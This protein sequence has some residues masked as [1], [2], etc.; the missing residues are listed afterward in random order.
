VFDLALAQQLATKGEAPVLND[1]RVDRPERMIVVSGPNQG[2]K[3]TF[4]RTFGQLHYLARLGL[5][6]PGEA[7]RLFLCDRIFM[8]FEREERIEDLR[9]KLMDELLRIR[10]ILEAARWRAR[11]HGLHRSTRSGCDCTPARQS[12]LAPR[13]SHH[14][15]DRRWRLRCLELAARRDRRHRFALLLSLARTG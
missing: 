2:G 3:T 14:R 10:R 15:G 7:A 5:P 8:H 9:G 6:V 11:R 4:A 1:F 12:P 13:P